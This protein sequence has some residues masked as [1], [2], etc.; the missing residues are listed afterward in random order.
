MA[1]SWSHSDIY[2]YCIGNECG[3]FLATL[4]RS[5]RLRGRNYG[6]SLNALSTAQ[7]SHPLKC[8]TFASLCELSLK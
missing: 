6:Q 3:S 5:K 2:D 8:L 7:A 1:A 4:T